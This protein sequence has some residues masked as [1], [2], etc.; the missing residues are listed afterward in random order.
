MNYKLLF[1][2]LGRILCAEGIFMLPAAVV[3][4]YYKEAGALRS[5]L[6]SSVVTIIFGILLMLPH[7]KNRKNYSAGEGFITVAMAW[8]ILSLFGALP[9][10]LDGEI[11]SY[12]DCVFETISGFTTTGASILPD[13]EALSQGLLYWRSFTHWLGG[14]GVLVFILAINPLRRGSGQDVYLLRAESPGP[15]VDKLVPKLHQSAKILYIIYIGMTLIEIVILLIGGMPFFDALTLS[16]G[17]AG[18]GGFAL[19]AD[20]IGSY[21]LFLQGVITVFMALFG[22]NFGVYYLLLRGRFK[23]ALHNEELRMYIAIMLG[24]S[25]LIAVNTHS[26]YDNW[27]LAFHHSAFQVSSIM[28]T[29]GYA[30]VDFNLWPEFSKVLLLLIMIVGACGGSTGGGIKVSRLLLLMKS[31]RVELKRFFS[32]R[33]VLVAH[34]DGKPVGEPTLRGVS[35]FMTSYLLIMAISIALLSLNNYGIETSVSAVLAC[36]NNIGPG[37]G[38][39]G[40][41]SS[42]AVFGDGT[43]LLLCANMLLGRLEILPMLMLFTPS[44]WRGRQ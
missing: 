4:F 34:M 7:P 40:P 15:T 25:I 23:L 13:V 10:Y 9:F 41:M 29:T 33:A 3:S 38:F 20:S 1:N 16:F 8:V 30:T 21:S 2:L 35:L 39:V 18:T 6:V 42:Y 31:L 12:V 17:T 19:R 32:P 11:P 22:V 27:F 24:A 26:M 37:L 44:A 5:I 43:K 14:M 28:T 36:L